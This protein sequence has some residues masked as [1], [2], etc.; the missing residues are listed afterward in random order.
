MKRLIITVEYDPDAVNVTELTDGF[1]ELM[2]DLGKGLSQPVDDSDPSR[3]YNELDWAYFV[4]NG[5]RLV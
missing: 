4:P 1:N 2:Y 5:E 3:L